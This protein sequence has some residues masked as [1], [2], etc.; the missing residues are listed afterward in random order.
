MSPGRPPLTYPAQI[1]GAAGPERLTKTGISSVDATEPICRAS[2]EYRTGY[3]R[4][5]EAYCLC[6][7]WRSRWLRK[8]QRSAEE[9]RFTEGTGPLVDILLLNLSSLH[10]NSWEGFLG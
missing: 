7:P 10:K 2:E 9:D 4:W 6:G 8:N 1:C 5:Q 3:E